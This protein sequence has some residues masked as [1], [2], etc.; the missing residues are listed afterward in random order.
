MLAKQ[1]IVAV[2]TQLGLLR[3]VTQDWVRIAIGLVDHQATQLEHVGFERPLAA[4]L[5]RVDVHEGGGGDLFEQCVQ[6]C[7]GRFPVFWWLA[8]HSSGALGT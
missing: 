1:P 7:D 8:S 4:A 2:N 6:P 5:L 3:V